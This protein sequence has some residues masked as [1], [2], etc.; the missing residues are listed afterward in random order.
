MARQDPK[1]LCQVSFC[2]PDVT[3]LLSVFLL[4]PMP[5]DADLAAVWELPRLCERLRGV[6]RLWL[7]VC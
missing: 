7:F 2:V 1:R 3:L 6:L 5:Y 4:E